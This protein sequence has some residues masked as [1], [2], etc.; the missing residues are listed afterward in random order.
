MVNLS[1]IR[2]VIIFGFEVSRC[3]I[4]KGLSEHVRRQGEGSDL[5]LLL[6]NS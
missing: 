3:W 6:Y 2:D 1:S 4:L 5:W